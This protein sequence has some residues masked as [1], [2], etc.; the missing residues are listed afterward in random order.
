MKRMASIINGKAIAE[1]IRTNL[2]QKISNYKQK[3]GRVPGLAVILV[4]DRKDSTTYVRMKQR[5]AETM[6]MNFYLKKFEIDVNEDQVISSI[7]DYN[8]DNDIHGI[9]V[10]LPLPEHLDRRKICHTVALDKDVDGLRSENIGKLA[11][12]EE[13]PCFEACTPKGCIR[14]LK[15]SNIP[16]QGK[17]AVVIGRSNIVGLPV[18]L[19]LLNENATVTICHHLSD[20]VDMV[21]KIKDADILVVAT[22]VPGL[23]KGEWLKEGATVIDVGINSIDDPTRKRGYKLV[24]DVDYEKACETL[25]ENGHITPVPGGVGPMTVAMLLSNTFESFEKKLYKKFD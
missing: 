11:M 23:I 18:A 9:I 6:G 13:E 4:G 15:E 22:G 2:S 20:Q 10:Q 25:G 1:D 12:L 5:A 17:N 3:L 24:G 14:L 8:N 21:R 7:N 19:M 16:I